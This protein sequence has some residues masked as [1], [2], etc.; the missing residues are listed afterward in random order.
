MYY[1]HPCPP[2][3]A[4]GA[5]NQITGL[6]IMG[7][8]TRRLEVRLSEGEFA[9]LNTRAAARR[10]RCGGFMRAAALDAI[11]PVVPPINRAALA[12]LHRIGVNLNQIAYH[13]N[14]TGG[15]LG[16]LSDLRA[17][18]AALRLALLEARPS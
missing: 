4:R 1:V 2:G 8:R 3:A 5:E 18:I 10:M 16:D 14:T 13:A 15:E 6:K 11:P 12:E 7:R 9:K 17:Q